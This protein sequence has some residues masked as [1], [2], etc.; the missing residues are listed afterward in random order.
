LSNLKSDS[1]NRFQRVGSVSNAHAGREFEE[2]VLRLLREDGLTLLPNFSLPIG[3]RWQREHRFDLGSADPPVLVECK[4]LKW[5]STGNVPMA[6]IHAMNEVMLHYHLAPAEFRKI[7]VVESPKHLGNTT[8]AATGIFS[9]PAS[10][11]QKLTLRTNRSNGWPLIM[12][13]RQNRIRFDQPQG[14]TTDQRLRTSVEHFEQRFGRL[15]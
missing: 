14:Q 5:T 2:V 9:R 7:L 1:L 15:N 12:R 4:S 13:R 8:C 3:Q 6:K 10:R 11:S